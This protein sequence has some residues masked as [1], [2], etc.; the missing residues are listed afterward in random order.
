MR[1]MLMILVV[2]SSLIGC[3]SNSLLDN[4]SPP[5]VTERD[6]TTCNPSA[7]ENTKAVLRYIAHLSEEPFKGVLSGQSCGHTINIYKPDDMMGY[8]KM[9]ENLYQTTGKY[10]AIIALDYEHDVVCKSEEI[11]KANQ[12]LI[13]YWNEG[14]LV[15]VG[16]SPQNP[17]LNDE[18]DLDNNPGEWT[19]TRTT[20]LTKEQLDMINLNDLI[21]PEKPVYHVWRHKLDRIAAGLKELQ[22]AGVVVLFKPMQEMNGNWFW[23]GIMSHKNDDAAPYVNLY[24]DMYDYFTKEKG[25]NNIIWMF[26]PAN[27]FNTINSW[28]VPQMWYYPGDNYVD[29]IAPTAYN[30]PLDIVGYNELISTC[31]PLAMAEYGPDH[32]DNH[33]A[34]DNTTYIKRISSD[35][36]GIAFWISWHDWNNGDGTNTYMSIIGNKNTLELMQNSMVLT[37]G[38]VDWKKY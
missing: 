37:R 38:D 17:W 31:K 3:N 10:P 6:G 14:G 30:S 29:I 26:S 20:E 7:H 32:M 28:L 9:T 5:K 24:R 36:T 13:K 1:K 15:A 33:G 25:L 11:S 16:M 21:Y 35:Y 23:W 2:L 8:T 34:F 18:S 22:D 27:N 19:L 4:D 12:V